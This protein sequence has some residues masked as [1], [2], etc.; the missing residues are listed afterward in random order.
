MSSKDYSE[1]A[2]QFLFP[3]VLLGSS[4]VSLSKSSRRNEI[5]DGHFSF[6]RGFGDSGGFFLGVVRE[7]G[8]AYCVM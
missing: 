5:T 8:F 7:D 2:G 3:I 4:E 6:L 1:K